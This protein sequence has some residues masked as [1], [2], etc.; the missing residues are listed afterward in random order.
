[1]AT[2][3]PP[4]SLPAPLG[5]AYATTLGNCH[6]GGKSPAAEKPGNEPP[7]TQSAGDSATGTSKPVDANVVWDP[8]SSAQAQG[9]DQQQP[10]YYRRLIRRRYMDPEEAA[11]D[12]DL[13]D[14][15]PDAVSNSKLYG[16]N[17]KVI[18][19]R[20]MPPGWILVD[21]KISSSLLCFRVTNR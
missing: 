7:P 9:G 13:Q 20:G 11:N 8:Q 6:L 5:S 15:T 4:A 19:A 21:R 10:R 2:S 14:D 12:P 17:I 1:M 16:P 18:T 3:I